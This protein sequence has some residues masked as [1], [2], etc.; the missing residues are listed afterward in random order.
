MTKQHNL[1]KSEKYQRI[2]TKKN[3]PSFVDI[4]K[5]NLERRSFARAYWADPIQ[6]GPSLEI[7]N[8]FSIVAGQGTNNNPTRVP[9][10]PISTA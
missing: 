3:Y 1:N 8:I 5:R 6:S 7:L 10:F 9:G 4:E 2:F